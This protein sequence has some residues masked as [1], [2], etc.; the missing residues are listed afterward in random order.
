MQQFYCSP[1]TTWRGPYGGASVG[2]DGSSAGGDSVHG[3]H[4]VLAEQLHQQREEQL[5]D[6][7][8]SRCMSKRCWIRPEVDAPP[9]GVLTVPAA[10]AVPSM[11]APLLWNAHRHE[12]HMWARG[13]TCTTQMAMTDDV[14]H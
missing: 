11:A 6:A 7:E 1:L 9:Q 12:S 3:V 2:S 13:V 5:D 4:R 10:P 14:V 8:Q